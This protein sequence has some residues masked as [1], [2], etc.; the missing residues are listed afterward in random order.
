MLSLVEY[1]WWSVGGKSL[2]GGTNLHVRPT[3]PWLLLATEP[4]W[5]DCQTSRWCSGAW[6]PSGAGQ[7]ARPQC[8]VSFW[9]MKALML[10][11]GPHVPLTDIALGGDPTRHHPRLIRSMH[12]CLTWRSYTLLNISRLSNLIDGCYV[13]LIVIYWNNSLKNLNSVIIYWPLCRWSVGWSVWV[14]CPLPEVAMLVDAW[15][16]RP[17]RACPEAKVCAVF[18]C[19]S[20]NVN[21]P[22]R[23]ISEDI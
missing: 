21:K 11:T 3:V 19:V 10:M 5:R 14:K 7:C 16:E 17:P 12:R 4:G 8:G 23:R 9:M 22:P 2:E 15:C 6:V 13:I 18:W 1:Q 20:E